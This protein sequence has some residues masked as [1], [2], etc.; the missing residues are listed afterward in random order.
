MTQKL[1]GQDNTRLAGSLLGL[2]L[3]DYVEEFFT[4]ITHDKN[5]A[6][7]AEFFDSHPLNLEADQ[8]D[9]FKKFGITPKVS[10]ENYYG[11]KRVKE[12]DLIFPI[13]T[14]YKMVSLD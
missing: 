7:M 4:G 5:M 9:Y 2:G 14:S 12:D 11:G 6:H 1:V 3:S 13:F 8:P 10:L